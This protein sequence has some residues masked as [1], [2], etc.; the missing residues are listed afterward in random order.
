[1]KVEIVC[2]TRY[3]LEDFWAKSALGISL[4]RLQHYDCPTAHIAASNTQGLPQVYN[5]GIATADAH[6]IVAFIHDDVWINDYFLSR[7]LNEGLAHYDVLGVAGNRRRVPGQPAWCARALLADATF[8]WEEQVNL[9]GAVGHGPR[10]FAA[11]SY[12]GEAPAD[13]ELLDGVLLA[14]RKS[15]L[16][17]KNLAF[18]SR[19]QFHFYD[20]DFCRAARLN[21]LRLG[22]WPLCV[23]HQSA[24]A[25]ST[26][27][28]KDGYRAYL[29]KWEP[30]WLAAAHGL[31]GS[32]R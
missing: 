3:S 31:G 12:F 9:S 4:R 29:E 13:C 16:M 1:M 26:E 6:S 27:P 21:G 14:A 15:V 20:M 25:F 8:Q 11:V 2:A 18:D 17:Q 32:S 19:F 24:G 22:T 28:W 30:E 23:T 7:R 5:D 10:P